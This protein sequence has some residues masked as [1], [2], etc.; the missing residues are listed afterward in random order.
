MVK[1]EKGDAGHIGP[2]GLRV[3]L[4]LIVT[5]CFQRERPTMALCG[6]GWTVVTTHTKSCSADCRECGWW[7]YMSTSTYLKCLITHRSLAQGVPGSTGLVGLPGTKGGKVRHILHTVHEPI[8]AIGAGFKRP[9]TT[10]YQMNAQQHTLIWHIFE[11]SAFLLYLHTKKLHCTKKY[12]I[13]Q[14]LV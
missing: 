13:Q 12:S 5:I 10:F 8:R 11:I 7:W 9:D 4:S 3:S 1:G 6:V 2:L 14:T